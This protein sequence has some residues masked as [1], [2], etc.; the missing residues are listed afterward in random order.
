MSSSGQTSS[1]DCRAGISAP[2][3]DDVSQFAQRHGS[4]ALLLDRGVRLSLEGI[5]DRI[6]VI[7]PDGV[8]QIG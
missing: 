2:L 7:G 3:T 5:Q 4:A 6:A 8:K 1:T